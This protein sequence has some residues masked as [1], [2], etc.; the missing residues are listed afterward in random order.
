MQLDKTRVAIRERNFIDI[1]DLA[2]AGLREHAGP[3]SLAWLAGVVP[4]SLFNH[5]LLSD[6]FVQGAFDY[7]D[8]PRYL[9]VLLLLICWELPLA[10]APITLYLGQALFV[11]R[12][13]TARLAKM[14][15]SKRSASAI[16]SEGR[17]SIASVSPSCSIQMTA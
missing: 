3:L 8:L 1:L 16:A 15:Q 17:A 5:W 10:M 14:G 13:S 12:P 6:S 9:F 7:S 2:L 4:V 11:E